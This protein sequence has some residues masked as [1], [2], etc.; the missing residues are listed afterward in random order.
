MQTGR[1]FGMCL[2][3]DTLF[4]LVK[5][6]IVAPEEAYAKAVEKST[7]V[8][9]FKRAGIDTSFALEAATQPA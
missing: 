9:A 4:D 5:K 3:N 1:K 8:Q 2:M 7:L 6:G